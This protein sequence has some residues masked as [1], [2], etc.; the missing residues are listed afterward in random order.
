MKRAKLTQVP[1]ARPSAGGADLTDRL[2][3][4]E[5]LAPKPKSPRANA[6]A[7]PKP[8]SRSTAAKKE[9]AVK[10]KRS[11]RL[12]QSQ[13][14]LV[15]PPAPKAS[16][17]DLP[18]YTPYRTV[19]AQPPITPGPTLK[20]PRQISLP[21]DAPA[22]LKEA[23]AEAA[24]AVA[25]LIAAADSAPAKYDLAL[26]YRLDALAHHLRQVAEFIAAGKHQR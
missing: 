24:K 1:L 16:A 6:P 13:A 25:A 18:E 7:P 11:R 22:P 2:L 8:P 21:A 15:T 14:D 4:R 5:G 26:R 23:V 19:E 20:S 3:A 10:S 12:S 17:G 9:T